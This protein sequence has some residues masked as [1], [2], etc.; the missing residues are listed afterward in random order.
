[1]LGSVEK[2]EKERAEEFTY[3]RRKKLEKRIKR[4]NEQTEKTMDKGREVKIGKVKVTQFAVNS[5]YATT[6]HKMQLRNF[7]T[8]PSCNPSFTG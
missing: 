6:C 3:K 2:E 1:M 4:G 7:I 5:N 8:R